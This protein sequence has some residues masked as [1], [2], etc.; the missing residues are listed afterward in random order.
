MSRTNPLSPTAP[1]PVRWLLL[2]MLPLIAL[3]LYLDGQHYDPGLLTLQP[4]SASPGA[5]AAPLPERLAGLARAGPLRAYTKD[6]L[7]EYING[8]AE[9]FIGA[10]FQGLAVGDYGAGADG[11]PRLVVNLYDLG[12]P[13]NAFGVLVNEA[14]QQEAVTVGTLGFGN[15]Q[16][17]NFI[18]GPW[19][20]QVSRFDPAVDAVAAARELAGTLADASPAGDLA[21]RFP[22]LGT[23]GA[24]RF[25]REFYHGWEFLNNVLE[26]DFRRDDKD[27]KAFLVSA[28]GPRIG[29]LV[30]TL[31]AFLQDEAIP[32]V[33]RERN[34]LSFRAVSDRYEGDW[35][36]VP[37]E[38]RLLGVFAPLDDTLAD[39][40]AAFATGDPP[41]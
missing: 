3:G 29:E 39:A 21:L 35:F 1:A 7:Y 18:H 8:H 13:L 38:G 41:P 19:Y 9:Y 26:R 31:E 24:T 2:L 25:V 32:L 20:A 14:G 17:V 36:F 5:A 37:L 34:G 27:F 40:I 4:G 28:E 16:G 30:T 22:D 23:A 33:H 11:Q 15:D 10:G 6:N 12:R